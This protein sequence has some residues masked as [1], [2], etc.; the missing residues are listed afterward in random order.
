MLLLTTRLRLPLP[1][2]CLAKRTLC[3]P[4]DFAVASLPTTSA[5]LHTTAAASTTSTSQ[6]RILEKLTL[7][8]EEL[9]RDLNLDCMDMGVM[10]A[11]RSD[12]DECNRHIGR[13]DS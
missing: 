13:A 12:N 6:N 9:P 8:F 11:Q 4:P 2:S 1:W 3:A 7:A 5:S 10:R